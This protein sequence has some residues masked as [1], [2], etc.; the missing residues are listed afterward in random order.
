[1]GAVMV[2]MVGMAVEGWWREGE[3]GVGRPWQVMGCVVVW[4]G[5]GVWW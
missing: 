5:V 4:V 3:V 1:M 2:G